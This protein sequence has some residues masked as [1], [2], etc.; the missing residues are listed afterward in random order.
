MSADSRSKISPRD[1]NVVARFL[2]A[3]YTRF[4]RSLLV[5]TRGKKITRAEKFWISQ[6]LVAR[7]SAGGTRGTRAVKTWYRRGANVPARAAAV[8]ETW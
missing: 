6:N 2:A 4:S 3:K 7:V 8:V 5:V 1:A